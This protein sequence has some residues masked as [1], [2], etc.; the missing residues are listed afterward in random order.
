MTKQR[1][2]YLV[3]VGMFLCLVFSQ[4]RYSVDE[5]SINVSGDTTFIQV[6]TSGPADFKKF[7]MDTPPKLGVDFFGSN[8]N[9]PQKEYLKVP[10]GI[11]VATRGSQFQSMPNP[12]SR[13][14]FDLL[15]TPKY[16]DVRSHPE[17]VMIA[18]YTP[19]YPQIAAWNS[20][21]KTP[22]KKDIEA[23]AESIAAIPETTAVE[24]LAVDTTVIDTTA[25]TIDTAFA[26]DIPPELAI[27]MRPE[28][29]AYKGIT[30]DR[31]TIEVAKYIRNMVIYHAIRDDPFL[32]PKRTKEVPVG[33]EAPP[34]IENLSV[35]GIVLMGDNNV[36]IMQD[37]SGFGF[38]LSRGDS[39]E[40]GICIEVTDTSALFNLLEFEQI[41]KVEIPLVKPKKQ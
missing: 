17:G 4:S 8:Y 25:T 11:I 33:Q 6:L 41:R 16:Y 13:I 27:Y 7:S 23:P 14:V 19:D 9:L 40:S 5:I 24:S 31:E 12:V 22:G 18:I 34:N 38:M 29:L 28:T 37:Q 1:T 30:A 3:T 15:E 10:P 21:R 35:V 2:T 39:V 32:A 26:K 36:A 20:G